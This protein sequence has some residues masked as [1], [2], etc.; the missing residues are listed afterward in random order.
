MG[1]TVAINVST[2]TDSNFYFIE[3][4]SR[5]SPCLVYLSCT[6]GKPEY[7]DS[8]YSVYEQL[9]WHIAVSG[10]S[11]NHRD[12]RLNETDILQLIQKLR[13]NPSIDPDRIFLWGFSGQGAMALGFALR[14][15]DLIRGA[16]TSCAHLGLVS[17]FNPQKSRDQIFYLIT[18]QED[19]NRRHNE[20][21]H[22][23]FLQF[24]IEDSLYMTS[25]EH[26]IGSHSEVFEACRFFDEKTLK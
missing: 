16:V 21:L 3:V 11:R 13:D 20:V 26:S 4:F 2:D 19:W 14:H 15:P 25:G 17:D 1:S 7:I 22:S 10:P 8:V 12:P 18:R 5:A 9:G 6:G 23:K 24:G